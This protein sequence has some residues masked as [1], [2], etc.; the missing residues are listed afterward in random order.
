MEMVAQGIGTA[1]KAKPTRKLCVSTVRLLATSLAV[2]AF[3]VMLCY[4]M[5]WGVQMKRYEEQSSTDVFEKL[6]LEVIGGGRFTHENYKDA[7]LTILNVW[8]TDCAPCIGELP[9]L[10]ELNHSYAPGEIQVVGLL[11][12]SMSSKGEVQEANINRA[13][14]LFESAG[15]TYPDLIVDTD[16]F[17]FLST[18]IAGTPTTFFI[19]SNGKLVKTVTGANTL[20]AWKQQVDDTLAHLS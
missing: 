13:Q 11:K 9:E 14:D 15:A 20:L 17:A 10:E 6:N 3:V 18:A 16:T 19:D 1:T 8:G 4:T 7:K 12:D 2:L 5:S